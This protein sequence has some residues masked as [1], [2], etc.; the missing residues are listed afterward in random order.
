MVK[1]ADAFDP[2]LFSPLPGFKCADVYAAW[3]EVLFEIEQSAV[4]SILISSATIEPGKKFGGTLSRFHGTVF[5]Q[6]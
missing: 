1:S 5:L 3:K 2:F 6:L 4:N